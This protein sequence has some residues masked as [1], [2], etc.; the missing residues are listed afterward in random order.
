MLP[1][2][3]GTTPPNCPMLSL[4]RSLCGAEGGMVLVDAAWMKAAATEAHSCTPPLAGVL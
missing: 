1:I 2:A 4:R 3:T